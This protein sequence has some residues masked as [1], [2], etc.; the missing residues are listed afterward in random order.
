MSAG[1]QSE[2][3]GLAESGLAR[4]SLVPTGVACAF[5]SCSS[6][7]AVAISFQVVLVTGENRVAVPQN[8]PAAFNY[9]C[10]NC[11]GFALA[12]QLFRD[13]RG[14]AQRGERTREL[15]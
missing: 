9:A 8:I 5:A 10:V 2:T 14:S 1:E 6:C 7:A 4:V 11:L 15:K 12:T 3:F 13:A